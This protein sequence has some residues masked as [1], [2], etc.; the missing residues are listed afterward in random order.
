MHE[1]RED[2]VKCY[3]NDIFWTGMTK[4]GRSES[5]NA[6]FDRYVHANTML[7]EFLVQYD[8]AVR[9]RRE[10]EEREDFQTMNTQATL[11]GSHP[12]ERAAAFHYTRRIFK[13][14]QME[15]VASADCTH[16]TLSKDLCE[17]WYRV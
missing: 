17:G 7:N 2:W 4:L 15:W 16:E 5:M 13:I 9:A 14:F 11:S 10:A 3:F 6:Y 12:I 8:K 1:K